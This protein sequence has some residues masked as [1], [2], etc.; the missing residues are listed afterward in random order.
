M[1]GAHFYRCV[2]ICEFFYP[3]NDIIVYSRDEC[4]LFGHNIK[5]EYFRGIILKIFLQ[6]NLA[7]FCFIFFSL[8]LFFF[9]QRNY[10]SWI[11]LYWIMKTVCSFLSRFF[12]RI[13]K[14]T[15]ADDFFFFFL[16]N[17]V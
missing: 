2:Y 4:F 9:R 5:I 13:L 8:N 16:W 15:E 3:Y 17:F 11:S 12:K 10:M 14:L 7:I 1:I 6:M